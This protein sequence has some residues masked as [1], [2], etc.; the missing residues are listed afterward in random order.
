MNY[1]KIR[2]VRFIFHCLKIML[3]KLVILSCLLSGLLFSIAETLP[4]NN[5]TPDSILVQKLTTKVKNFERIFYNSPEISITDFKAAG[6]YFDQIIELYTSFA[7]KSPGNDL[8]NQAFIYLEKK[9]NIKI[10]DIF[11]NSLS[12]S[13][14][15]LRETESN[16]VN[17]LQDTNTVSAMGRSLFSIMKQP[18][19]IADLKKNFLD[20]HE[21]ILNYFLLEDNIYVY[22]LSR[23][24]LQI[25]DWK[26]PADSVRSLINKLLAPFYTEIDLFE[27]EFNIPVSFQ[28]YQ[29]L[30]QPLEIHVRP[31]KIIYIIPDDFLIGFPFEL[32][33][34]DTAI[35]NKHNN[36]IYYQRFSQ[37]NFLIKKYAI[38][39]NYSTAIFTLAKG[40]DRTTNKLGRRLLTM[41]E[42][43]ISRDCDDRGNQYLRSPELEIGDYS[44]DEI[45]RVSRLLFRH[46][47]LKREQATKSYLFENGKAYRWLY[48]ALP[49][50]LDNSDP[51][52][53]RILFSKETR[54]SSLQSGW[55]TA[56]ESIFT[57]L[58]ADLLT[59]SANEVRQYNS[60]GNPGVV[61]LPQ[62][63]L[64]SGVQSILFSLWRINS[65][66]TSQFMSKFYWELKYKRQTNAQALQEAKI[67][68]MKDTFTFNGK[69]IS[70][71]HPYFWA[72]FQLVGNPKIR[73]PSPTRL[74]PW[75]VIII[76]YVCV[77][78]GSLYITRKT[79]P[80]RS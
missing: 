66:S 62:S 49:G 56:Y 53:S 1:D 13:N 33:V 14:T 41:S 36:E 35:S 24:T 31:Y 61:T 29:Y 4:G 52:N 7:L 5:D 32:L 30:F 19:D 15:N 28:L 2:T 50:I 16:I 9:K 76:V 64:F 63:F 72:T 75:G 25:I 21:A 10:I 60:D 57:T 80:N 34:T 17:I 40:L 23:D 42:P 37:L 59:L 69:K 27:L 8:A 65:I 38:S 79:L 74:P 67:A 6:D 48:L 73:P 51:I 46:D 18:V 26:V 20:D 22:L 44:S 47:N 45:K 54:D 77:I 71:A 78:V 68:S 3:K 43:I 70:R 39:Y 58:S 55:L 12:Q 11:Q